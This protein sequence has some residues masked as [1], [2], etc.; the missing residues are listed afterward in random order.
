M[1]FA[2]QTYQDCYEY[3]LAT[4]SE[5]SSAQ[6]KAWMEFSVLTKENERVRN[7]LAALRAMTTDPEKEPEALACDGWCGERLSWR[8]DGEWIPGNRLLWQ[9]IICGEVHKWELLE[10]ACPGDGHS[11]Q[12]EYELWVPN[13]RGQMIRS[14]VCGG[15]KETNS[16]DPHFV[17][18]VNG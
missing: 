1:S 9:C 10:D 6:Q 12:H 11:Y 16:G 5:R 13:S 18:Q 14:C 7:S 2:I 8:V 3:P 4:E 17:R 15:N